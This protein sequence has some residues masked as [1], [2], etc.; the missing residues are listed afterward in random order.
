MRFTFLALGL[1]VAARVRCRAL[2][3]PVVVSS[4][5]V[6]GAGCVGT[7]MLIGRAR[8]SIENGPCKGRWKGQWAMQRATPLS[9]FQAN[10]GLAIE[11]C[12]AA[13]I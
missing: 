3:G 1:E 4:S 8:D 5:L 9:M 11:V 6:Q 7:R 2:R 13:P 10:G 12:K